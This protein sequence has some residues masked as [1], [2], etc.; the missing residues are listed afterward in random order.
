MLLPGKKCQALRLLSDSVKAWHCREMLEAEAASL[1]E[2]NVKLRDVL[3]SAWQASA[4]MFSED[5]KAKQLQVELSVQRWHVS[6]LQQR[7]KTLS[8]AFANSA[9]Q[10]RTAVSD[11]L[12][13]RCALQAAACVCFCEASLP[14]QVALSALLPT[15]L[16][17]AIASHHDVT[18]MLCSV[19]PKRT[20]GQPGLSVL[21][22]MRSDCSKAL[23]ASANGDAPASLDLSADWL[24]APAMQQVLKK[25]YK[26]PGDVPAL[27]AEL[28]LTCLQQSP[29]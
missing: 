26:H 29:C 19:T 2:E 17:D 25:H 27:L 28:M 24:Q 21:L 4:D 18:P 8:E 1:R 23:T 3:L 10:F 14:V 13:W 16:P 9:V 5:R 12:G 20:V 7:L 15:G 11:L 22:S 6:D